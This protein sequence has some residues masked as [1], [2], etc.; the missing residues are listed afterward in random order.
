MM[1]GLRMRLLEW[2]GLLQTPIAPYLCGPY[3]YREGL[4]I[5]PEQHTHMLSADSTVEFHNTL[6]NLQDT[7]VLERE[8]ILGHDV[9]FL[10]GMHEAGPEGVKRVA[11]CRGAIRVHKGAWIASRAIIL[12]GVEIGE[13]AVIGAGSVVTRSVPAREFWAG[14]P[15]RHIRGLSSGEGIV[16]AR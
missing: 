2:L 6:V 16:G 10:T 15:A 9:M 5:F 8:V 13:G 11:A 14:N 4:T 3:S 12:G 7:V 1:D